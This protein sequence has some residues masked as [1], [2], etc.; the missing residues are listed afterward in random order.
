MFLGLSVG[1][2]HICTTG[3]WN[4]GDVSPTFPSCM[5][6]QGSNLANLLNYVMIF[7][8]TLN[9]VCLFRVKQVTCTRK[10]ACYYIEKLSNCYLVNQL[11]LVYS[12]F[13]NATV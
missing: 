2:A 7:K 10:T 4:D 1:I 11:K 12:L 6:L 13:F 3:K 8:T 5:G 9:L